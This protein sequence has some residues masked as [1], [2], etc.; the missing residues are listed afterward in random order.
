MSALAFLFIAWYMCG[1]AGFLYW[2]TEE[3]DVT[4]DLIVDMIPLGML[5]P[6][7]ILAGY[8]IHR[9]LSPDDLDPA[10]HYPDHRAKDG[11][12]SRRNRS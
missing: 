4:P 2:W 9:E 12:A 6:L 11:D 3:Y 10:A 5:G 1:V 7:T 8:F